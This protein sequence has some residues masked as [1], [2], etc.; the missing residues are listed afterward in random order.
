MSHKNRIKTAILAISVAVGISLVCLLFG[1]R[2]LTLFNTD[3]NAFKVAGGIILGILGVKMSLG[4]AITDSDKIEGKSGKA[5]A[6]LIATPLLTGPAAISTI[7][8]TSQD[9]GIPLTG[10]AILVVLIFTGVLFTQAARIRKF[11]GKTAIQVLSTIMGLITLSWS[12]MF[13]R[14]GLGF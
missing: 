14:A 6:S 13:I 12:I 2:L 5:I 1:R 11:T 7:I 9:Y 8:I 4:Q 3:I 10:I